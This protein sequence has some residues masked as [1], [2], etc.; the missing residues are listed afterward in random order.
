[1]QERN[2]K[3]MKKIL[4]LVLALLLLLSIAACN[5]DTKKDDT[6][7]QSESTGN[8]NTSNE[9]TST[10]NQKEYVSISIGVSGEL[11]RFLKGLAPADNATACDAVF[12]TVFKPNPKTHLIESFVLESWDWQ[13][14]TTLIMKMKDNVYF[15]N[16]EQATAEDLV[17]SYLSHF[18]RGSNFLNTCGLVQDQCIVLDTL[19]AQF[20]FERPYIN[21]FDFEVYLND[22]SWAESVGWDS[23]EWYKPV[24]S[25]PYECVEYLPGE[26][27]T[28]HARSDY[29][30]KDA[31]DIYVDEW[32]IRCYPDPTTM[33]M[34]LE[35]GKIDI[36][37]ATSADYSRYLKEGGQGFDCKLIESGVVN[38]FCF[39][40]ESID[41]FKDKRVRE[42]V[43]C[44]VNWE[45]LGIL[46]MGDMYVKTNSITPTNG[47]LYVDVGDYVFDPER[48]K[49][50]LAEAGYDNGQLSLKTFMMDSPAYRALCE[51]FQFYLNAIGIEVSIEY[52]DISSAIAQWVTPG[53]C[54]FGFLWVPTGS[55]TFDPYYSIS[56]TDGSSSLWAYVDDAKFQELLAATAYTNDNAVKVA[57][58]REL[59]QYIRDEVLLIPYASA[60]G[61]V[62]YNNTLFTS[63]QISSYV[64]TS[65]IYQISK[66]GM[67]RAWGN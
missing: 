28:L 35:T 6:P 63:D 32:I 29:W 11:G 2:G 57:K 46:S 54:N 59:Q 43:A 20:K 41:A 45:E 30:N 15:S 37:S 26:R 25:G 8:A 19:T 39:G 17:F 31:G 53:T 16:G 50:L 34:E 58:A 48:A 33:F 27:I 23:E 4:G 42:A 67:A 64:Q 12:D 14:D 18:E 55:A 65:N 13:D 56:A 49:T 9:D 38:Y 66:L 51:G 40:Y 36:C 10:G 61:V 24:G 22:K 7:A 52:G 3:K 60:V 5:K 21:F 62:G 1:M 47:P 44:G